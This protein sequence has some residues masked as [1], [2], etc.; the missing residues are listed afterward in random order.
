[1]KNQNEAEAEVQSQVEQVEQTKNL[2]HD[3]E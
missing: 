2:P 3:S 1:M